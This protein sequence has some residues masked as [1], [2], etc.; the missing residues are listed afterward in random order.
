[1]RRS[2]IVLLWLALAVPI[3]ACG[4][5]KGESDAGA[6]TCVPKDGVYTCLGGSWPACPAG[7]TPSGP[8]NAGAPDCMGCSEGAGFTC[9]CTD[10]GGPQYD[11][12]PVP[13]WLCIGTEYTC[14]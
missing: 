9:A 12:G 1:V 5:N 14:E 4:T 2:A 13:Y 3:V 7:A 11:G 10:A 6:L 8:C